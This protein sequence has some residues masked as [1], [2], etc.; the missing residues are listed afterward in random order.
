MIMASTWTWGLETLVCNINYFF[1]Q[2]GFKHQAKPQRVKN[3]VENMWSRN[4]SKEQQL[5]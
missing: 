1:F 5:Q 3:D 4:E 2:N